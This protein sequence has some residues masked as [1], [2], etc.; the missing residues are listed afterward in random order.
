VSQHPILAMLSNMVSLAQDA[1]IE[2]GNDGGL[3]S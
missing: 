2:L 1:A 3:D